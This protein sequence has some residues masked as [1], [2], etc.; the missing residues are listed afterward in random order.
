MLKKGHDVAFVAAALAVIALVAAS[1]RGEL[2]AA[3]PI[4]VY[5]AI[6]GPGVLVLTLWL[7]ARLWW[8]MRESSG[9]AAWVAWAGA[10]ALF[11]VIYSSIWPVMLF[12]LPL[13][14][15]LDGFAFAVRVAGLAALAVGLWRW[16]RLP[17][18]VGALFGAYSLGLLLRGSLGLI[19][20][21]LPSIA[22]SALWV[23][24]LAAL[25]V[26]LLMPDVARR[27]PASAV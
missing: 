1:T 7:Y 5:N 3:L 17:S 18:W 12:R 25:A 15:V 16:D 21:Q 10:A 19:A 11:S 14:G 27:A 13:V 4:G 9:P 6:F 22:L 2:L 26:G 24:G 8:L 20:F 23:V